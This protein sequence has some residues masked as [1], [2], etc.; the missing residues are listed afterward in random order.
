MSNRGSLGLGEK[1]SLWVGALGG[2][3]HNAYVKYY[4]AGTLHAPD[5]P[6]WLWVQRLV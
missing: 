3:F 4:N 5:L 6:V 2:G 1:A